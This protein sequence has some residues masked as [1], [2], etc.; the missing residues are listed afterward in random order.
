MAT[1]SQLLSRNLTNICRNQLFV[2]T[3]T[4]S[5][6]IFAKKWSV[7][8]TYQTSLLQKPQ[9]QFT[10]VRFG[11]GGP[12]DIEQIRDRTLLVLK[13]YDKILYLSLPMP[14]R[15]RNLVVDLLLLPCSILTKPFHNFVFFLLRKV[16]HHN[17]Q[18]SKQRNKK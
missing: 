6:C 13:L 9:E 10:Q 3:R 15:K 11:G 18:K 1:L 17:K 14:S 12:P 5:S 2:T 4:L 16:S 7:N 8:N